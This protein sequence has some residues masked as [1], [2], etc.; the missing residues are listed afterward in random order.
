MQGHCNLSLARFNA[1]ACTILASLSVS[2]LPLSPQAFPLHRMPVPITLGGP[3]LPGPPPPRSPCAAS[4]QC[5]C[6]ASLPGMLKYMP[7]C[8]PPRLV[9]AS[10]CFPERPRRRCLMHMQTRPW[11]PPALPALIL[12][13]ASTTMACMHLHSRLHVSCAVLHDAE[14]C[15]DG[16]PSRACRKAQRV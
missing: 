10:P 8:L 4:S 3:N 12:P 14:I 6:P 1:A 7:P 16:P 9:G 13:R 5:L 11:H 2:Y 15:N